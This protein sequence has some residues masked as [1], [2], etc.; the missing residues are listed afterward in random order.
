VRARSGARLVVGLALALLG[1]PLAA[2]DRETAQFLA[3]RGDKALQAKTWP[4]AESLYRRALDEDATFLPARYGLA[5]ALVGA[6]QKG[7][8]LVEMRRFVDEAAQLRPLPTAWGTLVAKARKRL[9]EIDAVG[10]ELDRMIDGHVE[11]LLALAK[12]WQ[13]KDPTVAVQAVDLALRLRPGHAVAEKMKQELQRDLGVVEAL[14]NGKDLSGWTGMGRDVWVVRD[15]ILE[16]TPLPDLET[17]YLPR[18]ETKFSGNFDVL[19]EAKIVEGGKIPLFAIV[20]AMKADKDKL[21]FGMVKEDLCLWEYEGTKEYRERYARWQDNLEPKL[22]PS[23]WN[24]YELRFR[25]GKIHAVLNGK[26]LFDYDRPASRDGGFVGLQ[27]QDCKVAVKR[28]EIVR[29]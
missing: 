7:P 28:V 8:G 26:E 9:V 3:Q 1:A 11:A 27:L 14:F 13:E 24:V 15:G 10:G 21:F 12:R 29:R 22:D 25:A 20:A 5:E 2:A 6:G 23:E 18:T 19:M 16:G 4:E 17:A